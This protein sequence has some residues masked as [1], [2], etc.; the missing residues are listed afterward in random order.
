MLRR[1]GLLIWLGVALGCNDDV[2]DH[3]LEDPPAVP[4]RSLTDAA[5]AEEPFVPA[6]NVWSLLHGIQLPLRNKIKGM[7]MVDHLDVGNDAAEAAHEY[8]ARGPAPKI[9]RDFVVPTDNVT[10][11]EDGRALRTREAFV[12]RVAP[13]QDNF[14]VK[15]YDTVPANQKARVTIDGTPAGEWTVPSG[16]PNRYGEAVFPLRAAFVGQRTQLRVELEPVS[17]D[18]ETNAFVYWV[19]AKPGRKLEAPLRIS[20]AG[21]WLTDRLDVGNVAD[22]REHDYAIEAATF[23]GDQQFEWPDNGQPFLEDGRATSRDESFELAVIPGRDHLLVKAFD[24]YS[25]NQVVRVFV[26]KRLVGEWALPDGPT[27]YGEGAL[28]IPA[29]LIGTRREISVRVEFVS[30]SI[31]FNSFYYWMFAEPPVH[32][33]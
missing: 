27:R 4:P 17:E 24:T 11:R 1:L 23:G 6:G 3:Q 12:V 10:Y 18:S 29:E 7:S 8:A 5:R 20:V 28:R 25:K 21:L 26:E 13:R 33:G 31:E 22:E 14:L 30:A 32:H 15:A 2:D 16:S 19:F 9:E